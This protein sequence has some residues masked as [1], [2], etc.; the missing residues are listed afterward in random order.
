MADPRFTKD[1]AHVVL[2]EGIHHPD[3][4]PHP[5]G[6][7]HRGLLY[8]DNRRPI[9]F[10]DIDEAA[11]VQ[12]AEHASIA[13]RNAKL[14]AAVRPPASGCR[15]CPRAQLEIQEAERR[16][17][18][19]ELHDEVGQALTAVKI[20][21]QMLRRQADW[22]AAAGRLDDSLGMV[23]RIL[24]GVRRLSLDLRPSLLDDLGLA[25]ALRW[26]VGA[27]A[28]RA[29]LAE[30]VIAGAVPADLPSALATTCFRV[31]QEA[32]TNVVR[33]AHATRAHRDPRHGKRRGAPRRPR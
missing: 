12:L 24:H 8:V 9:P 7:R 14:F 1:T 23:D 5:D 30:E 26:Y 10:T 28:Q 17:I 19:R 20:N 13:I 21:L 25:A 4:R 11:L 32:V 6:G 27:Q 29:G 33:H 2:A 16:H 31:A 3:D 15:C 18:A 22:D